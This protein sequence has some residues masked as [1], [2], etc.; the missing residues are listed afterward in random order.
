MGNAIVFWG[1]SGFLFLWGTAYLGLVAFTFFFAGPEHWATL[2]AQGRIKAQYATYIQ[3]IPQW[4]TVIT[5]LAA[6]TRFSGGVALLLKN[7]WAF[8]LYSVSLVLVAVL[9]FRGFFLADVASVIRRS[10]VFLEIGF[11]LCS[12]FAVWYAHFVGLNSLSSN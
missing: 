1:V 11:L 9:M 4:V 2:V 8:A 5:V 6:L 7:G 10:Q 3:N 12:V